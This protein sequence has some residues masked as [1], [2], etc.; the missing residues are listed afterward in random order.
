[1]FP[2][3][4]RLAE[5]NKVDTNKINKNYHASVCMKTITPYKTRYNCKDSPTNQQR[6]ILSP[7][8]AIRAAHLIHRL[9]YGQPC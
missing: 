4:Q 2:G 1:M 9:G 5:Q 8:Y 7:S 6:T 3:L